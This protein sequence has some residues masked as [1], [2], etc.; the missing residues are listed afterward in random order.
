[1]SIG[2]V[3][4][5]EQRLGDADAAAQTTSQWVDGAGGRSSVGEEGKKRVSFAGEDEV[6]IIEDEDVEMED[7]EHDDGD[8]NKDKN[9]DMDEARCPGAWEEE[10]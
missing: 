2:Y 7:V 1:M 10:M 6:I 5:L 4:T 3:A 9:K 8:E